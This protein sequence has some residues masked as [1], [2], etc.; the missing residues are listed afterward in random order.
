M[1]LKEILQLDCRKTENYKIVKKAL[2]KLPFFKKYTSYTEI[3]IEDVEIA[4][5]K[6][7]KKYNIQMAYIMPSIINNGELYYSIMIKNRG[8]DEWIKSIYGHTIFE[9]YIKTLLF[10]YGYSRKLKKEAN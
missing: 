5:W 10:L 4:I 3:S 8:T 6:I 7:C 1:K 9:S 2:I